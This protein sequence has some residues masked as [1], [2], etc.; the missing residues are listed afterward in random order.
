MAK[1]G[2]PRKKEITVG[3]VWNGWCVL[4]PDDDDDDMWKCQSVACGHIT[5][6]SDKQLRERAQKRCPEC[7]RLS[8]ERRLI[9]TT[10]GT[11][12][13]TGFTGQR[14]DQ[15]RAI[16]TI[17]CSICGGTREINREQLAQNRQRDNAPICR[18]C[19]G[20]EFAGAVADPLVLTNEQG[21]RALASARKAIFKVL[22]FAKATEHADEIIGHVIVTLLSKGK[23]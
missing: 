1:R 5:R 15:G 7:F 8:D 13:V 4:N 16:L 2:R 20:A 22:P 10:V 17:V 21:N 19:P 9:G 3:S 11:F 14:N 12:T 6:R 23:K 18:N